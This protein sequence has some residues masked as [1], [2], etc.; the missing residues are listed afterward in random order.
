[1]TYIYLANIV[2]YD[3]FILLLKKAKSISRGGTSC[4]NSLK[5][6][7]KLAQN[8]LLKI[9]ANLIGFL[10]EIIFSP[11]F[12]ERHRRTSKDFIRERILPFHTVIFFLTNLIK[13]SIQDELDYFFKSLQE[14]NIAERNVTKSAF[15]KA[16]K[17]LRHQAFIELGQHLI[18]FFYDHF[19]YRR[20]NGFRLLTI[21]GSTLQVP[22]SEEVAA[23]FGMWHPNGGGKCP[24]ARISYLSDALNGVTI[25]ALICPKEI[26]E[27]ILAAEHM[28]NVTSGDLL[29]MDRGYPAFWLFALILSKGANFCSRIKEA[30]WDVVRDFFLSGDQ[31]QIVTIHPS[32]SSLVKCRGFNLPS[33]P[34]QVR[35]IRAELKTGKTEILVTSLM[36]NQLYPHEIFKDLYRLRWAAEENYKTAKHRVEIENFSGKSVESVYQDFHAKTF[37][38]NLSAV[39]S[40]PAQDVVT[41]NSEF[42]KHTYKINASQALSKIKDS[43]VLLFSRNN[44]WDLL[45]KLFNIFVKTIEPVRPGRIYPRNHKPR[46]G[47]YPSYNPIR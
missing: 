41:E 6:S 4:L 40:H 27:R 11:T 19:T 23:H 34:F 29:L 32:P 20:W 25:D 46:G 7:A 26:G 2:S 8:L 28:K 45:H 1:M 42:K 17:K 24:M 13:G 33:A 31:E 18:S 36:D 10:K 47:F 30:H 37:T 44:V 12:L 16:R 5:R 22:R 43:I 3:I 15:T 14:K 38:M 35:L 21:D 9:C 39:L